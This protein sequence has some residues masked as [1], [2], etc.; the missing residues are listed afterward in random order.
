MKVMYGL[1][2]NPGGQAGGKWGR[3][4]SLAEEEAARKGGSI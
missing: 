2:V 3:P 1:A 4:W